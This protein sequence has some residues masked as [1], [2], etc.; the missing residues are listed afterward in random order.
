MIRP[1]LRT[2]NSPPPDNYVRRLVIPASPEWLGLFNAAL[3]ELC[4]A[5]NYQPGGDMSP[6]DVAELWLT[7]LEGIEDEPE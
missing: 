4:R 3:V 6:E 7:I 1:A 5:E 2:P